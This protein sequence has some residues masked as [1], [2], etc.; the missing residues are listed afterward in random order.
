MSWF[1]DLFTPSSVKAELETL[2]ATVLDLTAE[3]EALK[4]DPESVNPWFD[5]KTGDLHPIHGLKVDL[6]WNP[7][8]I[9]YLRERGLVGTSEEAVIQKWPS[10]LYEGLVQDMEEVVVEHNS[11]MAGREYE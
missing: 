7:A 8:M 11:Q 1:K 4:R 3:L 5:L 10:A 9:A 6:D 2:K